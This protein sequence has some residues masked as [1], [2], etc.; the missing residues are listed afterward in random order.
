M[1]YKALILRKIKGRY[2]ILKTIKFKPDDKVIKYPDKSKNRSYIV[3]ME[4]ISHEDDKTQ[5]ICFD[6]DSGDTLAFNEIKASLSPEDTDE[7]VYHNIIAS[8]FARVFSGLAGTDKGKILTYIVIFLVGA[9]LGYFVNA[10]LHT[11]S[12]GASGGAAQEVVSYVSAVL[13]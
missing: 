13:L 1:N 11:Q 4:A 10:S 8:L 2:K 9:L 7:L 3:N 6:Y 5:Y 12:G